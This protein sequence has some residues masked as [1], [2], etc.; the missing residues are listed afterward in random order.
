MTR[1]VDLSSCYSHRIGQCS[2]KVQQ[3]GRPT[4]DFHQ[5]WTHLWPASTTF[6]DRSESGLH[7]EG[8]VRL[9]LAPRICEII[10]VT[11]SDLVQQSK[12]WLE[13][14]DEIKGLP[15]ELIDRLI[16]LLNNDGLGQGVWY[17]VGFFAAGVLGGA[18]LSRIDP[19]TGEE[20]RPGSRRDL[21]RQRSELVTRA[22]WFEAIEARLSGLVMS[23]MYE[24]FLVH[25]VRDEIRRQLEGLAQTG[26]ADRR[27][28]E[29]RETI[30]YL[31]GNP[32]RARELLA[33]RYTY[34]AAALTDAEITTQLRGLLDTG[35]FDPISEHDELDRLVA[36]DN[37][38]Q[39][40]DMLLPD[41]VVDEWLNLLM[42]RLQG[43]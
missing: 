16:E 15:G 11:Y 37:W 33:E 24:P 17:E 8:R 43:P 36:L 9:P 42:R 30:E 32:D 2:S 18:E 6:F 27:R 13:R 22:E 5:P 26:K 12:G 4:P 40:A 1:T 29:D 31:A 23:G 41:G 35:L 34:R 21:R 14:M 25:N 20:P 38:N 39:Q 10:Y 7:P 19:D 28:A 3:P